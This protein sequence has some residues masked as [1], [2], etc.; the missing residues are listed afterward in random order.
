MSSSS[1][2]Q[3]KREKEKERKEWEKRLEQVQTIQNNL[4]SVMEDKIS[5]VNGQIEKLTS[6]LEPAIKC[7][8]NISDQCDNA[9]SMKENEWEANFS[10]TK[11]ALVSEVRDINNK[12]NNL[13][14]EIRD[15]ERR[16]QEA[17]AA[18]EEERRRRWEEIKSA[19]NPFD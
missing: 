12:I 4:S 13:N 6:Q 10:D 8:S 11:S 15:L 9:E 18:E 3:E 14:N 17:E 7:I 1:L 19:L 16:I 5:D 2:K